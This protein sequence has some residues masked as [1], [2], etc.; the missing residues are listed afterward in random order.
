MALPDQVSL[1]GDALALPVTTEGAVLYDVVSMDA[2]A[3]SV[4]NVA[5]L[6]NTNPQSLRIGTTSHLKSGINRKRHLVRIDCSIDD[7]VLGQVPYAAYL[8]IDRPIS[9]DVSV[10]NITAAIGRICKLVGTTGYLTK[11]LNGEP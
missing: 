9:T 1:D 7:S 11:V 2:G 8:V 10:D 4:R 3:G 6:A 5:A